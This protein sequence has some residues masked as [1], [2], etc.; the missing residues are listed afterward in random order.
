MGGLELHGAVLRYGTE[1]VDDDS[2]PAAGRWGG[3]VPLEGVGEHRLCKCQRFVRNRNLV[4]TYD[5]VNLKV[6]LA[7]RSEGIKAVILLLC[8]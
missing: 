4:V 7:G 1:E 8:F 2:E 6:R 3:D 5:E